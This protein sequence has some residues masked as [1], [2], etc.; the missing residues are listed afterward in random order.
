MNIFLFCWLACSEADSP[1][2]S[3][4]DGVESVESI[5]HTSELGPI[6]AEVTLSP[7]APKLGQ[8]MTLILRVESTDGVD[9][10][11]PP[12]GEA[13]G[14]FQIV[15]FEPNASANSN[16]FMQRYTLQ[17][18]M[19]GLQTIPSLRVV[20]FDK[21]EGQEKEE[22][23][24]LTEEISIEIASLLEEDA[25]LDFKPARGRLEP[26][27]DMPIWVWLCV[28]SS[29][30]GVFSFVGWRYY[31]RWQAKETVRSAY[32]NALEALRDLSQQTDLEIDDYYAQLSLI[33]RRYIDERF[34]IAV[35]EKTTPEFLKIAQKSTFFEE[36]Q[37]DFL[38][39][40]LQRA[41]DVKYAQ[42]QPDLA[43]GETE[44]SLIRRFLEETKLKEED[45]T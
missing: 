35:L 42:Q 7:K 31:L 32:E 15:D 18:P 1:S 16:Q 14:R 25:P 3:K 39:A 10:E 2:T 24:V 5:A 6:K 9:V 13:L 29:I 36:Q 21:R 26:K 45:A 34:G 23:E 41:D 17:A 12:F 22:Q 20:F 43:E 27:V 8:P 28:L 38:S 40:F 11:L 37:I 30:V 19:S 44:I 33:L 4:K